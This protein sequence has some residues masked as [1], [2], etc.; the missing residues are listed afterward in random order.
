MPG[1]AVTL[2]GVDLVAV[3]TDGLNVLGVRVHGDVIGP[4]FAAIDVSGGLYGEGD[5]SKHLI[6]ID[7]RE[8]AAG[9]EIVVA[10][11]D[12][13][14]SSCPGKTIDELYSED[15]SPIGPRQPLEEATQFILKQPRVRERFNFVVTP[16]S[17]APIIASTEPTNHSFGFSVLWNWM[18]PK[19]V[20]VSLSSNSLEN[21][22]KRTGGVYQAS[23]YMHFGEAVR[24]RVDA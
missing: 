23:F 1:L 18:H 21:I 6:W 15:E 2:N 22:V 17:G 13:T 20:R 19:R 12:S 24:L 10:L 7:Q 3:S 4:E 16:P 9:D 8:L 5:N 14:T 11:L